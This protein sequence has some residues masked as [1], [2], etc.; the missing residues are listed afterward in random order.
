MGIV[1]N[2]FKV[3]KKKSKLLKLP[4]P[5]LTQ[6]TKVKECVL[7]RPFE[8]P[9]VNLPLLTT[10]KFNSDPANWQTLFDKFDS[11]KNKN[12]GISNLDKFSYQRSCLTGVAFDMIKGFNLINNNY[13]CFKK[14]Q[15]TYLL[16]ENC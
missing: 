2:K 14:N 1:I 6:N 13:Q 10:E 9:Y 3:K 11:A 15:M 4:D 12:L 16:K 8:T 7:I 5:V